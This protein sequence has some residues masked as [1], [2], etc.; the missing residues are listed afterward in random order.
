MPF[1]AGLSRGGLLCRQGLLSLVLWSDERCRL[2]FGSS[3][4][5]LSCKYHSHTS[6][7]VWNRHGRYSNFILSAA[8]QKINQIPN[9]ILWNPASLHSRRPRLYVGAL[10]LSSTSWSCSRLSLASA[11]TNQFYSVVSYSWLKTKDI[12]QAFGTLGTVVFAVVISMLSVLFLTTVMGIC[13]SS[14]RNRCCLVFAVIMMTFWA[15]F[16]LAV[17]VSSLIVIPKYFDQ[18]KDSQCQ[19]LSPFAAAE[20]AALQANNTICSTACPCYFP[21]ILNGSVYSTDG[22]KLTYSDRIALATSAPGADPLNG[23]LPVRLQD[24]SNIDLSNDLKTNVALYALLENRYQC[25]GW[26]S[27]SSNLFY[28]FTDV[29][30]GTYLCDV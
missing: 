9:R 28:R 18:N 20:A 17:G 4:N 26:C 13:G 23:A 6:N 22:K 11:V 14:K 1:R 12:W 8:P 21:N 5:K 2:D 16:F 7:L 24:C 27:D 15:L 19:S 29:N 30:N 3:Q 25:T 10:P